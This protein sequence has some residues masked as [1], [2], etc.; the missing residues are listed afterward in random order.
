MPKLVLRP[1]GTS[2]DVVANRNFLEILRERSIELK[3]SCGGVATCGDCV[4]KILDGR[5]C[6][7]EMPFEETRL[8]G[9]VFHITKER[10]ACQTKFKLGNEGQVIIDISRHL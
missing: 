3:S 10:L 8:L 4:V 9:N 7:N 2:L 1:S 5:D 6:L